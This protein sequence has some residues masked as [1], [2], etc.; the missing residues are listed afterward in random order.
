[1]AILIEVED[2]EAGAA[3]TIFRVPDYL[4]LLSPD[5]FKPMELRLGLHTNTSL[6]L[7]SRS[8]GRLSLDVFKRQVATTLARGPH[9]SGGSGSQSGDASQLQGHNLMASQPWQELWHDLHQALQEEQARYGREGVPVGDKLQAHDDGAHSPAVILAID[10]LFLCA[11]LRSITHRDCWGYVFRPIFRNSPFEA[12]RYPFYRDLL[13]LDNQLPMPLLLQLIRHLTK[14]EARRKQLDRTDAQVE[15]AAQETLNELLLSVVACV[16]PFH[17]GVELDLGSE[18]LDAYLAKH[19]ATGSPDALWRCEHILACTYLAICGGENPQVDS[20][21]DHTGSDD[22]ADQHL[23]PPGDPAAHPSG[24]CSSSS[25]GVRRTGSTINFQWLGLWRD[26]KHKKKKARNSKEM[27]N[28]SSGSWLSGVGRNRYRV[29]SA[30][31]LRRSGVRFKVTPHSLRLEDI[32]LDHT[33]TLLLPKLV[34]DDHTATRF[35]NLALYEQLQVNARADFRT[36]LLLMTS[37]VDNAQDVRLLI[38]SNVLVNHLSNDE[39]A[40][41]HW[42]A[43]CDGLFIPANPPKYWTKLQQRICMHEK[44][45]HNRWLADFRAAH[46]TDPW[47]II[48]FALACL[49]TLATF[50]QAG[51]A[52]AAFISGK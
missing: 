12:R 36:Y 43:M 33:H 42:N 52:I 16:Y 35:R 26:H 18:V 1:M 50:L 8:R 49:I 29:P 47:R 22:A 3:H 4:N 44:A 38:E 21:D 11:Y 24:Y 7:G 10:A 30:T 6:Q 27:T 20:D 5:N 45:K 23:L 46:C 2:L 28:P 14:A 34:M 41:R 40:A 15:S 39:A 51:L 17:H 31:S 25:S 37:L 9:G 48:A 19:F 13:I 32:K